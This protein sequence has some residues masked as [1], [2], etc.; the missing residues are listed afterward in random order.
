MSER[1]P[2]EPRR[3]PAFR[4]RR[5][6]RT[7]K[8]DLPLCKQ[9]LKPHDRRHRL[10][11]THTIYCSHKCYKV[12]NRSA[13]RKSEK[14]SGIKIGND[15][16]KVCEDMSWRR[17]ESTGCSGCGKAYEPQEALKPIDPW[18][19]GASPLA[20]AERFAPGIIGVPHSARSPGRCIP[21]IRGVDKRGG[22]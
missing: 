15:R 18:N 3:H 16:C 8:S 20:R 5:G 14:R 6:S 4:K 21:L 9:C 22:G 17:D 12:A 1:G 7:K 11:D 10:L 2:H 19:R 13:K